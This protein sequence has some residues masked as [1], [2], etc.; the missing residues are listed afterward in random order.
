[1]SNGSTDHYWTN[2]HRNNGFFVP[3]YLRGSSYI[4][5]LEEV[6]RA[7]AAQ[8]ELQSAATAS[9]SLQNGHSG[10][11]GSKQAPA[12]HMG[13]KIDVIERAPTSDYD[14]VVAP[15]PS[16]WNKDD[17]Y[18]GLEVIGDGQEVK[19][20]T[21]R[22]TKD[23]DH[24]V[25]SIRADHAMPNQAGIYYFEISILSRRRDET[26]VCIGVS[27][28][29]VP[30]SRPPGWEPESWGYHGDDGEVYVGANVGKKYGARFGPGDFVGCGVNFRTRKIFFTRNGSIQNSGQRESF[31][32]N[33]KGKLYP[34]IGVKKTGE[35]IRVNFG[36]TPF[37][38]DIDAMMAKEQQAIQ[39]SIAQT[40]IERL[41]PGMDETELIQQL[42]L[43]FLQHDGYVETARAFADE[44]HQEKQ[45]LN[46]NS[47]KTIDSA[48]IKDDEDANR[49]QRIR[50]AVLEGDIDKALKYTNLYYPQVLEENDHVYFKLRCRKFIEM[51]RRSAEPNNNGLR[52]KSSSRTLSDVPNEMDVDE[53][54]FDDEME[55]E[56][57]SE[58]G[59]ED[60]D[61]LSQTIAYG[62]SLQAEF[63]DDPRR[64]VRKTL[65]DI[66][67]L[68]A[69]PNPLKV[70]ELAP[71]LDRRG[72]AAVAEDL[73]SAILSSLGKSSRSALE[74]LYG[75]T[76]VLLDYLREDGGSGSF[77]SIQSIVDDIPKSPTF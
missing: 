8:R 1:M 20:N 70:K 39:E 75:Q 58:P 77:V 42:V 41:V 65:Q 5:K 2:K 45:A 49:R 29:S 73:N 67:A 30:L 6:H 48:T 31:R 51:V 64:D 10:A 23:Q 63:K 19:Y 71:Q 62:Q 4:Q 22:G 52:K 74:T 76:S 61:L 17:K 9:A 35:H 43:Q 69:Y 34:T 21:S 54:G 47:N 33:I 57:G 28:K 14:D 7:Q 55:T 68:L 26:S 38:F 53:N 25:C 15:L 18:G 12:S 24:E 50:R 37:V 72:R 32:S 44:I 59:T 60:Q 27:N 40:S 46:L 3:S 13:M 66:F 56:D 11:S 16:K 36:H